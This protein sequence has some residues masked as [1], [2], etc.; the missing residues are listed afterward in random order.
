MFDCDA[1][2][3]G[4]G[5][6]GLAAGLYL[7]RANLRAV[8]LE[9]NSYGGSIKNVEWIENYPGFSEGVS[10]AQLASQM[11]DQACKYGLKIEHDEVTGL[12]LF[13]SCRA[14]TCASGKSY[15]T[16]TIII[17]GGSRP[18]KL[19]VPGEDIVCAQCRH[20]AHLL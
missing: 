11:V 16:V 1:V 9:G 8:L 10:G 2:I 17:A 18:K 19:G 15:T 14:V 12:E 3:I 5:P 4:G 6:A 20:A 7:G 13:S